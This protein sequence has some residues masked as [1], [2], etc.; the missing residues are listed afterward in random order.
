MSQSDYERIERLIT[1][2]DSP[3][4]IDAKKTHVMI[5]MK[6]ETIERPIAEKPLDDAVTI[7]LE[8]S[9][10][11]EVQYASVTNRGTL[12]EPVFIRMRP[13]LSTKDSY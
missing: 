10:L 13:D 2:D 12:R 8:P 7:W 1:A 5:L 6:L 3:V 11:C 9:L 4:G